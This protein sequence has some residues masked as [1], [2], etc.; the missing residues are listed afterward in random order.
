MNVLIFVR[1]ASGCVV[2]WGAAGQ[3]TLA[4]YLGDVRLN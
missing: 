4:C 1:L 2:A 3:L